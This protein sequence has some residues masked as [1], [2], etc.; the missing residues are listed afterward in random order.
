M[1]LDD[2]WLASTW[3]FVRAALPAAPSAVLEIGCGR[4]GG[5]VPAL[6]DDGYDAIGVDPAAP[7]GAPYHQV[8]F[9]EFDVGRRFDAA[10]ASTSLH[11]VDDVDR[12]VER[13]TDGLV[14][15]GIVIVVEWAWERFDEPTAQ[16][17]FERLAPIGDEDHPSWL[18]RHRDGWM[19]SDEPWDRYFADWVTGHGLHPAHAIVSALDTRFERRHLTEGPYFFSELEHTTAEQEQSAIDAGRIR[20]TGLR[21]VGARR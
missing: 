18:H 4:H 17:C 6:L 20:A 13:M 3:P 9:E 14:P 8:T 12:V 11:H 5:F 7:D 1:T 19:A 2:L 16:W 10:V 15:E 21:Y